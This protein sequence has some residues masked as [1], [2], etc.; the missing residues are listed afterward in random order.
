MLIRCFH[1]PENVHLITLTLHI[2]FK[3][4]FTIMLFFEFKCRLIF[5]CFLSDIQMATAGYHQAAGSE[6]MFL[7]PNPL[8]LEPEQAAGADDP[9]P[10]NPPE[11]NESQN[12]LQDTITKAISDGSIEPGNVTIFSMMPFIQLPQRWLNFY[13]IISLWICIAPMF[14]PQERAARTLH[15]LDPL[16]IML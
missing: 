11:K 2:W 13:K 14:R 4:N 10:N 7:M 3:N 5:C 12:T 16:R 9:E 15:Y 6:P 1:F 8:L